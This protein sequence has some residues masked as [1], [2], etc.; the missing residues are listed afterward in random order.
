MEALAFPTG[1]KEL[2]DP[3]GKDM[4]HLYHIL[5]S[6]NLKANP[7]AVLRLHGSTGLSHRI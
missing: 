1:Y 6:S 4:S 7:E 5:G 2:H 3:L